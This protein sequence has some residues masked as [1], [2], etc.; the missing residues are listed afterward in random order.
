MKRNILLLLIFSFLLGCI[1]KKENP[2]VIATA[3]MEQSWWKERHEKVL[4]QLKNDPKLILIGNS[5]THMLD[6]STRRPVR[7]KYLN[8]YN[9]INMGFSGDRTENVIWRLQNGEI[10]G[11][12]PKLAILLIGT[13]N[14]DGNHYTEITQPKELAGAIWKICSIIRDKLP[15]TE[16]LLIGI[17]PYGYNENLRN[18][19]NKATNKIISTFPGKDS[20]IHYCDIGSIYLDK[21]G[22]VRKDLMSDYLHP[23]AE[24]HM[25]MFK[26]LEN[27]LVKFIGE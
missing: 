24:G 20:K 1:P 25:L 19:I 12:H 14:T 23:N 15:D 16:I 8:R 7:E 6:D 11:I 27:D 9:T 17:L 3:K 4:E 18:N 21:N 10:E 5:I 26:A 2:A 13:N 22:N